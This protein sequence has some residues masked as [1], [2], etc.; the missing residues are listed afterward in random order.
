MK[1]KKSL[2]LIAEKI[3]IPEEEIAGVYEEE[4]EV[5]V[6]TRD[7]II[8]QLQEFVPQIN[9]SFDSVYKV[10]FKNISSDLCEVMPLIF[11]K[12]KEARRNNDELKVVCGYLLRNA[13]NTV[14][15]SV[16]ILRCGFKLQ[17]GILLRSVVEI[18]ATVIHLMLE[19][20]L[21]NDFKKGKMK[22]ARS[23]SVASKKVPLFGQY[24]GL[25]SNSFVHINSIHAGWYPLGEYNERE[26]PVKSTLGII[27]IVT[28]MIR[29][30]VELTF[31]DYVNHHRY[32]KKQEGEEPLF[33]LT[34]EEKIDWALELLRPK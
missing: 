28:M 12:L 13:T 33:I 18:C 9:K 24:W 31:Y 8:N 34:R 1:D 11:I 3:G 15:S 4:G 21:L 5:L 25:M 19:P 30:A 26:D 32:W 27:G 10:E 16:Q 6:F 14:T 7:Q 29:I 17:G 22:S 23:I 20:K 2:K